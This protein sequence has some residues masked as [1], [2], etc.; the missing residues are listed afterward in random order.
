MTVHLLQK[1]WRGSNNL[2]V[3]EKLSGDWATLVIEWVTASVHYSISDDF[4]A[5]A[6]RP[7][8]LLALFNLVLCCTHWL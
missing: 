8:P 5:R 2:I 7:E 3:A 1:V 4:A 6:S